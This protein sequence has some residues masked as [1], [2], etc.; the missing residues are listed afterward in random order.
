MAT[1]IVESRVKEIFKDARKK[2]PEG[3]VNALNG[4]VGEILRL[5]VE[6]DSS[7]SVSAEKA[8]VTA[9][10]RHITGTML[11]QAVQNRLREG[12]LNTPGLLKEAKKLG[13][14]K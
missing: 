2:V 9:T 12:R 8:A 6:K 4:L 10:N 7:V 11:R 1:F 5:S 3:F 13:E 14:K